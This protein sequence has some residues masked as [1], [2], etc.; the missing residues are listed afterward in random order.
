MAHPQTGNLLIIIIIIIIIINVIISYKLLQLLLLVQVYQ[1][2]YQIM[3]ERRN[4]RPYCSFLPPP[5]PSL[6]PSLSPPL[7]LSL[8]LLLLTFHTVFCINQSILTI[9]VSL[10]GALPLQQSKSIILNP[11]CLPKSANL[12][13]RERGRRGL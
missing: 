13:K 8:S 7:S 5:S 1:L 11:T 10:F 9:L 2:L 6:S 4:T 12:M 3:S